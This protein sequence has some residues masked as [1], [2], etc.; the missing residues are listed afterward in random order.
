[1]YKISIITVTFNAEK[2]I[3]DTLKSIICQTYKNIELIVIDG[4]SSDTTLDILKKYKH[5]I[6]IIIS[7]KDYGIY[8][9]MNKGIKTATGDFIT[10][11]NAGDEYYSKDTIEDLFRDCDEK[12]NVLY[13]DHISILNNNKSYRKAKEF[14]KKE[15]LKNL[16]STVCH[17][18]FF[19]KK[20]IV[21][22]YNTNYQ[23]KGELDWYFNILSNSKIYYQK[24]DMPVVYYQRG[25][26]GEK[27]YILNF[28]EMIEVIK[29]QG[30]FGGLLISSKQIM[31]YIAKIFL[32]ITKRYKFEK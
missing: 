18:A 11:L 2:I 29:R 1:M 7:E 10:F 15:L 31:K 12:T 20:S 25:G 22:Y 27:K 13:G 32:I 21:P 23:L 28:Y 8:D 16:T 9:A 4:L 19:I 6:D 24:K 3:E 5:N 26:V 17:Q 30:G 14:T